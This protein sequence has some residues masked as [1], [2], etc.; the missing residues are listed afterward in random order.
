MPLVL[1]PD[2]ID[3]WLADTAFAYEYVQR[4]CRTMLEAAAQ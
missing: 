3:A 2:N 1:T 4:P